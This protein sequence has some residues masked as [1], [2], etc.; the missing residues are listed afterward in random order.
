MDNSK[1]AEKILNTSKYSENN[2]ITAFVKTYI[3]KLVYDI[4]T[5]VDTEISIGNI[6]LLNDYKGANELS[7]EVTGIPSAYS[8]IDGPKSALVSFAK[9]YSKLDEIAEFDL[10]CKEVLVDFLN[11]HNG[12]FVV[13]LS[14]DKIC[15]LSLGVPK[16]NGNYALDHNTYKSIVIIPINF[17]YGTINFLLCEE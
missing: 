3:E 4:V 14:K 6:E 1:L 10:L 17:S 9:A 13:Q 2:N 8:V 7:Q 12:L 11:L 5:Y 15:E 16:Q